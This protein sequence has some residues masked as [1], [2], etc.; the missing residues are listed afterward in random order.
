[1]SQVPPPQAAPGD[2]AAPT[3]EPNAKVEPPTLEEQ[4]AKILESQTKI[5]SDVQV[6]I[7]TAQAAEQ[8]ARRAQGQSHGTVK[9]LEREL[10]AAR[11]QLDEI[12]TRDMSDEQRAIFKMQRE[13]EA[14]RER[15]STP[16]NS[17]AVTD[18]QSYS[19][20]VLTERGV[21]ANDPRL[22]AAFDRYVGDSNDPAVWRQGLAF[23]IADVKS[24]EAKLAESSVKERERLAREEERARATATTRRAAGPVDRGAPSGAPTTGKDVW[25]MTDAEFAEHEK[26]KDRSVGR[27]TPAPRAP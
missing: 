5:S 17:E 21:K 13:N 8:A 1:M 23:A 14:L 27:E 18:F 16:D 11:Q 9:R 2:P 10:A 12:V 3:V 19:A 20:R 26:A 25:S 24:D 6:A 7:A 15:T 22:M 4:V